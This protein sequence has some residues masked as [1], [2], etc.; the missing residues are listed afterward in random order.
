V[1]DL[2]YIATDEGWLYIA[3]VLDLFSRRIV[4]LAMRGRI[5]ADLVSQALQQA[6]IHRKPPANLLH[7]SDKGSQY[8]SGP[9][10]SLLRANNIIPSMSALIT[11]P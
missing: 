9:F 6:L 4:G 8:T 3:T 1:A 10:L 7:H 5:I 2:T 11:L